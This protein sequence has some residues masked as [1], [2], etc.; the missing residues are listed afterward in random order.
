MNLEV[1][2]FILMC[3]YFPT[4]ISS[5]GWQV[6]NPYPTESYLLTVEPVTGSLVFVGGMG[7]TLLKSTDAGATWSVRKFPDMHNIRGIAFADSLK[8]W[9][10]DSFHLYQT[11]DSGSAWKEIPI[12]VDHATYV[13]H[14]IIC[15]G[16]EVYILLKPFTSVLDELI[17]ANSLILKSTDG[18]KTWKQLDVQIAGQLLSVFFLDER[19]GFLYAQETVSIDEGF[20]SFYKTS[21]GGRT[22]TKIR[23]PVLHWT[24][25]MHFVNQDTGF[26]G[27]YRTMDGGLTW[28]NV[29]SNYL[30]WNDQIYDIFFTDSQNGWA[31][32]FNKIFQTVD[33]GDSW[34]Q[35]DQRGSGRLMDINFSTNG[36]GWIVGWACNIF[37]KSPE[38]GEWVSL[39]RGPRYTLNDVLFVDADQ[40]WC[41]GMDGLI[42]HTA[43]GGEVWVQQ[44]SPVD[45]LLRSVNFLNPLN[46]WIAGHH[47][48]LHTENG[49]RT[50]NVQK[51]LRLDF[52]DI[53]FFDE[54]CGLLI[55]GFGKI[56][57]TT[58]GGK[59]WQLATDKE[60]SLLLTSL[61]I[62]DE[63]EAWI[64][65]AGGLVHT[66]DRG[67]TFQWHDFP[68][69]G[70][71]RGVQFVD[72]QHGWLRNYTGV[73][74]GTSDGGMTWHEFP[75][76]GGMQDGPIT[77]FFMVDAQNGWI[78]TYDQGGYIKRV[79]ADQNLVAVDRYPVMPIQAMYFLNFNL[80]WA[81]GAGGTILK[82]TGNGSVPA[83]TKGKQLSLYPN[84]HG[85]SGVSVVFTLNRS[86]NVTVR[87]FNTLG[88]EEQTLYS[89]WLSSGENRIFWIPKEVASGVY[90][91]SV[92]CE[93]FHEIQKCTYIR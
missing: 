71:V 37:K 1:K 10:L 93:E 78:W 20:T 65:G 61:D 73:L 31:V 88:Q 32:G 22:W 24:L 7:G 21:D 18:G 63:N 75:R 8:G 50:W 14:D 11:V 59:D 27:Q 4:T 25:G 35:L 43:N 77:S 45:S 6:Q 28:E 16:E 62:V 56:F 44:E 83:E 68:G 34:K 19:Y 58:N 84:P 79:I 5:L 29:F 2:I 51:D 74:F 87:V 82:Y 85:K 42:M 57:R 13:F 41:V 54:E 89:G 17:H 70:T 40:G 46:G 15:F 67:Q 36:I 53:D 12:N 26:V 69:L 30:E 3:V 9:I 90:L 47:V 49:G 76:G 55:D 64:G 38:L 48:V 23:F 92:E 80:G 72:K 33:G 91:I 60:Y 86:Q 39:S 81:V 52:M 66:T